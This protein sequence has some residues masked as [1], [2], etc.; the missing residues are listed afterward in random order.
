MPHRSIY[1]FYLIILFLI[2]GFLFMP[3][4]AQAAVGSTATFLGKVYS[5]DGGLATNGYL[6]MPKGFTFGPA[7]A[8][9]IADTADNAIRKINTSGIISTFSG[10]GEYGQSDGPLLKATWSG[11][12]GITYDGDTTFYVADTIANRIRKIKG[13]TVSTLPITGLRQPQAVIVSG[14][15]LYIAD[16]G[17]N[18][19]VKTS[20]NGG[21]LTVLASKIAT[22]LKMALSGKTLYVTEL[23]KGNILAIDIITK[24][25]TVL[26]SGFTE[27]RA[28]VF[29]N[30]FIYITAGASGIY[31]EIWRINPSTK[32]KTMLVRRIET[33]LL[34]QTSDMLVGKWQ[35]TTRFLLLQSGGSSIYTTN[36]D[37][38][39]LQRIAGRHRYGD[40]S[41]IRNQALLGRPQE[42]VASPDGKK[43]Y[44]AYAQGNKIA[45][46][47]F[48]TNKVRVV[49][50]YLMDN[51]REG[52]GGD[53]RFSDVVSM[54]ISPDGKTLY[55]ADRNNQRIRTLDIASGTTHYLTGAGLI[56]LIN[57]QNPT[58]NID[59]NINNGY[60]EGG[61]CPD[62]YKLAVKGCAYFNRPTGLALTKNGKIL[63]VAD[64]SNDR[65]R[66]VD[67]ATGK[68]SLIAGSG[69]KGM[70]NGVGSAA[71]FNGP[72]TIAL[73]A[74]EKT[75]YVADK[76]NNAIR[77]IDLATKRVTTLA[78]TGKPGYREG[79]FSKALFYIPEYI[80]LGPDGNL[81]VSDTSNSRIRKLDLAK[82][83][84]SLIAGSSKRGKKDGAG[85]I[86][87]FYLPKG[88]AFLANKIYLADF[89]ND[90]IRT[91][92]LA[93][94][95]L[96]R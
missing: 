22:P 37:G 24:K 3:G 79:S 58:G 76:Y 11:P 46:F 19:V 21:P 61:P 50:G 56:N 81:Y 9:F 40:E 54:A 53:A 64:G 88:K 29:Y 52:T 84:T 73:S 55:L 17:N 83:E 49:A 78:G 28:I 70:V 16:T 2:G 60:Q 85:P 7:G 44:I 51:Y 86:S 31:N 62:T 30:K 77:A 13:G 94:P 82:K 23:D 57:P 12:E 92:D 63:Y 67:V 59:V 1:F 74:N 45:E 42:I 65:I 38:Q 35:G 8:L 6:D 26:A 33:E 39:D 93:N 5:G 43:L 20:I 4:L 18:R 69:K 95:T 87:E 14:A 68:T 36:L 71:S 66:K 32:E 91:I 34:N 15:N 90:L 25:R 96:K 48:Y 75:L 10:S 72:Y 80:D 27:P 89:S 47:N 41:G